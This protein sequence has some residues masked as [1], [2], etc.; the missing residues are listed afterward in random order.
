M[1]EWDK[2]H[3]EKLREYK[4]NWFH[5]NYH[6]I[7]DKLIARCKAD[8]KANPEK[9]KA[10]NAVTNAL[11]SGKLIRLPCKVCGNPKSHAHHKDYSRPLDVEWYCAVHHKQQEKIEREG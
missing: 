1:T 7:K 3:P 9:A 5:R 8:R 2:A 11:N 10:R 4:R 6:R